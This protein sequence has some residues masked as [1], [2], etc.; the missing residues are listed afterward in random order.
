MSQA[1]L[2]KIV[3]VVDKAYSPGRK[4]N[5]QT[6]FFQVT[7]TKG[8]LIE[9]DCNVRR[10]GWL[11]PVFVRV[12]KV[13]DT[14]V[15]D[16][17]LEIGHVGCPKKTRYGMGSY[18]KVGE[19]WVVIPCIVANKFFHNEH[20][21]E[22]WEFP[23]RG[24]GTMRAMISKN[25]DTVVRKILGWEPLRMIIK[26]D[27]LF[28]EICWATEY[29][30]FYVEG[31]RLVSLDIKHLNFPFTLT[32]DMLPTLSKFP[33]HIYFEGTCVASSQGINKIY[34]EWEGYFKVEVVGLTRLQELVDND[35][36]KRAIYTV[37]EKIKELTSAGTVVDD[38]MVVS[39]F[40]QEGVEVSKE[41][42]RKVLTENYD[43]R[44]LDALVEMAGGEDAARLWATAE[45]FIIRINDWLVWE[46][47]IPSA[48]TYILPSQPNEEIAGEPLTD[49]EWVAVLGKVLPVAKKMD[50]RY[51]E[52]G[53]ALAGTQNGVQFAIHA[54]DSC[55]ESDHWLESIRSVV[56]NVPVYKDDVAGLPSLSDVLGLLE[57]GDE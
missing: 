12:L 29:C 54:K 19:D 38:T 31:H 6:F 20:T 8:A 15:V 21:D 44:Y 24:R 35:R 2:T 7:D 40:L 11:S 22:G 46:R 30:S 43:V 5:Y 41:R 53:Q 48:A 26:Q 1:T 23:R 10:G 25:G 56:D 42:A 32:D 49:E 51:G 37:R 27:V 45:G 36:V 3:G 13:P 57:A 16:A 9:L 28:T 14:P 34:W 17:I 18:A 39:L 47:C 33:G 4:T 55:G 52:M 50:L